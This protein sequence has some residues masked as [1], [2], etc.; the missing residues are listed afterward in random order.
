MPAVQ[1]FADVVPVVPVFDRKNS[2]ACACVRVRVYAHMT[3]FYVLNRH[4]GTVDRN[5]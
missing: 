2:H 5:D 4:T 1:A 3:T